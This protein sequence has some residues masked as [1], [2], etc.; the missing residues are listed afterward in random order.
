ML[1]KILIFNIFVILSEMAIHSPSF[2]GHT[3]RLQNNAYDSLQSYTRKGFE[4][5]E[6][7]IA[8]DTLRLISG[9]D[10][11]YYPFGVFHQISYLTKEQKGSSITRHRHKISY[12]STRIILY[13]MKHGKSCVKFLQ[14]EGRKFEIVSGGI[15]DD[16]IIL[17][18]KIRKGISQK[19]FL[20]IFFQNSM[21]KSLAQIRVVEMESAL[22]GIW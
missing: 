6:V 20:R 13:E 12:D 22:T 21:I 9:S 2:C 4:V 19:D 15:R 8:E 7:E 17:R 16:K 1:K 18:N 10:Y 11:L 5:F 14:G 3:S